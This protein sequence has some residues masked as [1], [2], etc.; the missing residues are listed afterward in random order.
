[1]ATGTQSNFTLCISASTSEVVALRVCLTLSG[2]YSLDI[3]FCKGD[4]K[5]CNK[6]NIQIGASR[7][8]RS[9]P[10]HSSPDHSEL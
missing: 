4:R 5:K 10:D 7:T 1:M 9:L 2:I 8:P 6:I 3:Q